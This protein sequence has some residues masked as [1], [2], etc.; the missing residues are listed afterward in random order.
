MGCRKTAVATGMM[1]K[2]LLP[3]QSKRQWWPEL[4]GIVLAKMEKNGW[5]KNVYR[6]QNQWSLLMDDI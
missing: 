6:R 1:P 5:I 4:R 3:C 2:R